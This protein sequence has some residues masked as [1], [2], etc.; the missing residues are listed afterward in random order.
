MTTYRQATAFDLPVFVHW[1]NE[2]FPYAPW[3]FSD[4]EKEFSSPSCH[5]VVAVDYQHG[6]IGFAGVLAPG[7][8][9]AANVSTLGVLPNH[10]GKGVAKALMMLITVWAK[11]QGTTVMMLQVK[12]DNLDAIG[13]YEKLGYSKH[14]THKDFYGEGLDAHVMRLELS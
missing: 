8:A 9:A 14:N 6:I 11:A 12:I 1:D 3:S 5:F 4:Y 7:S 10:R 2:L 13:L